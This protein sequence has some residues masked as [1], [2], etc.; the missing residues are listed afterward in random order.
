MKT[1]INIFSRQ[2]L[3]SSNATLAYLALFNFLLYMFTSLIGQSW[4]YGYFGDE[5]YYIACA[6]HLAFGYVDHPPLAPFLLWIVI[7]TLGDSI[8]AIR[9]LPAL[10]GALTVF[11]TGLIARQIGAGKFGQFLAAL[12]LAIAPIFMILCGFFS[13]NSFESLLWVAYG[14][15]V[16]I[17]IKRDTP[18]L[19]LLVGLLIGLGLLNKHT[20][21]VYVISLFAGLLLTPARKYFL[22][23]WFWLGM[24][25]A[26]VLIIPNVLWQIQYGF[27]SLEFYRKATVLKNI[28]SSPVKIL[29]DQMLFTNPVTVPI[30]VIG[31]YGY[32]FSKQ[33]KP[34]RL[35]GWSYL[36]LLVVMIA[37]RSSRPDRIFAAY[38]VL[39]AAGA[40]LIERGVQQYH[41]RVLS[42]S[43]I[44]V[45]VAGGLVLI[46]LSLPILPPATLLN[47]YRMFGES[48]RIEKGDVA[49][50][51]LWLADRF[52][53]EEMVATVARVY[54]SLSPEEQ[55]IGAI[56]GDRYGNAGAVDFFGQKYHLP[57]AISNHNT[58]YLWGPGD[59][60]GEVVIVLGGNPEELRQLFKDVKQVVTLT[61]QYCRQLK[62]KPVYLCK[63]LQT[64]LK[65]I[66]PGIK[67]YE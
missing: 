36:I 17:L 38:P 30:W 57:N 65:E 3:L 31:L 23:K 61:C 56:F 12:A 4:G 29:L 44:A 5:L 11:L 20:L 46:P 2:S 21:S 24:L 22:S 14:Y 55:A 52:G 49:E 28:A 19:W 47:Y 26:G 13:M 42:T 51:P 48:I 10:A 64:P 43:I 27:P 40:L 54:N 67:H 33:G 8:L 60:T 59:A 9:F 58:Y 62:N 16:I 7:R 45:L 50:L 35:F 25:I 32:L 41:R 53:W 63:G 34:Y 39:F 6:K 18:R 66:W 1:Q 15:V 37:A